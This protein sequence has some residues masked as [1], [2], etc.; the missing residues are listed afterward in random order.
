MPVDFRSIDKVTGLG[1]ATAQLR[2]S[3]LTVHGHFAG[4]KGAAQSAHLHMGPRGIP[5]PAIAELQV[6]P[7]SEGKLVG[8]IELT[9]AQIEALH[10]Q[11]LYVQVHSEAAP[12]GNLRGW[13]FP[14]SPGPRN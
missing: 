10:Q 5:G 3:L 11:A 8:R 9:A 14:I 6:S 12:A 4:L 2:G 7:G 1:Q 13:L